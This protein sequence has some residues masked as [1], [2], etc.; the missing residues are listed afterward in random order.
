MCGIAGSKTL[1]EAYKLYA[2]NFSRG[3]FS[4][5][6]LAVYEKRCAILHTQGTFEKNELEAIQE[7]EIPQYWLLHSRAPTNSSEPY[8]SENCHPFSCVPFHVA[9]NGIITNRDIMPECDVDSKI[10]PILL[11]KT[12]DYTKTFEQLH[13]LITCWVYNSDTRDITLVKGGS[14]LN[15]KDGSF[16]T[17]DFEGATIIGDGSMLRYNYETQSFKHLT[18][19]AYD[20]PY[21]LP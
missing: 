15:Y 8:T 5:G 9:H 2:S 4:S 21:Y 18:Y 10:I 20:N 19:F 1:D 11:H 7:R 6:C 14:N 13:G 3:T 12:N 17:S 16:C